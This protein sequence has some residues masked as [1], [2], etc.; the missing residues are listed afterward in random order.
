MAETLAE[1]VCTPCRGGLLPLAREEAIRYLGQVRGWELLDD[2]PARL[3][4][5]RLKSIESAMAL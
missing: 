3:Y 2:A 5:N 1:K 4:W